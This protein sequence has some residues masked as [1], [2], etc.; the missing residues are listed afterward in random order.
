MSAATVARLSVC[1]VKGTRLHTV[2]AITLTDH[3]AVGY[4]EQANA[5][6]GRAF[7]AVVIDRTVEVIEGLL[8]RPLPH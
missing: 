1:P 8:R 5:E 2:D 6:K 3:G 7:L 4:P